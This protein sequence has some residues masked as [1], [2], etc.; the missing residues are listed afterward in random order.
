MTV[1]AA[2]PIHK[3]YVVKEP[4]FGNV[5]GFQIA[6]DNLLKA[7]GTAGEDRDGQR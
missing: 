1:R 3:S 6:G 7:Q 4:M 5:K 2:F